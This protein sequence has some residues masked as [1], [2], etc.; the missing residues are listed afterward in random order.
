MASSESEVR[1]MLDRRVEAC[2]AK[3]LDK[4]MSLYASD[5]VY[6]DVVPPLQFKGSDEV[7]RN[8]KRWFDEYEGSIGL[9]TH[10]LQIAVSADV[11]F[12]H[13]LH[14]D[15]GTRNNG[16]DGAVWIRSTVC[17][18]RSND[19]WLITHEHISMPGTWPLPGAEGN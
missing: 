19:K 10:E 15:S 6:F 4:L 2:R 13:M 9:E 3:D 11:A 12:V 8:F 17:C 14:V 5:I 7:R 16:V 18:R 1:A